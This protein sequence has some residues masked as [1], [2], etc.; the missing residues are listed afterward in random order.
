[1]TKD[2]FSQRTLENYLKDHHEQSGFLMIEFFHNLLAD[3]PGNIAKIK[4]GHNPIFGITVL[5]REPGSNEYTP[6]VLEVGAYELL[7]A[8]LVVSD[9]KNVERLIEAGNIDPK[10]ALKELSEKYSKAAGAVSFLAPELLLSFTKDPAAI[11]FIMKH[12]GEGFDIN[13]FNRAI[14]GVGFV[15][16]TAQDRLDLTQRLLESGWNV[17]KMLESYQY[18]SVHTTAFENG[19]YVSRNI[20]Q[21][22]TYYQNGLDIF[23]SQYNDPLYRITNEDPNSEVVNKY[24]KIIS[25]MIANGAAISEENV[26]TLLKISLGLNFQNEALNKII[27]IK[28]NNKP[29]NERDARKC[30]T[31][32]DFK[33]FMKNNGITEL[34]ESLVKIN[35][36]IAKIDGFIKDGKIEKLERRFTGEKKEKFQKFLNA[37]D[38]DGYTFLHKALEQDPVNIKIVEFLIAQGADVNIEAPNKNKGMEPL[39][40]PL[41]L[42]VQVIT[43]KEGAEPDP[44]LIKLLAPKVAEQKEQKEH[45][46][47][48]VEQADRS[49]DNP[50]MKMPVT[51]FKLIIDQDDQMVEKILNNMSE[52][53]VKGLVLSPG[54][55]TILHV[56]MENDSPI[57]LVKKAIGRGADILAQNEDGLT[58]MGVAIKNG[59]NSYIQL[60]GDIIKEM[61]MMGTL[62]KAQIGDIFA[63][64]AKQENQ[65][66]RDLVNKISAEVAQVETKEAMPLEFE[67]GEWTEPVMTRQ[68]TAV[69]AP[70]APIGRETKGDTVLDKPSS[71]PAPH[72]DNG[73]NIK[74]DTD[75]SM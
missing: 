13:L 4:E 69:M 11:D 40:T 9:M 65:A 44:K 62:D 70:I 34:D 3:I 49:L 24:V 1:M 19:K 2:L 23:L 33:I 12:T 60:F 41:R 61:I 39:L 22:E 26:V 38:K 52:S 15:H 75:R 50:K 64:D 29:F 32:G 58:P 74:P 17:N 25:T 73:K 37:R 46:V 31:L 71:S 8:L 54:N 20:R 5:R 45:K 28:Y 57:S 72:G 35:Y 42:Y 16:E 68:R 59:N 66:T 63:V 55:R 18:H 27:G 10:K 67:T 21:R 43:L 56:M 14:S 36:Q 7:A 47:A 53:V 30:E 51:I 6:F 48:A